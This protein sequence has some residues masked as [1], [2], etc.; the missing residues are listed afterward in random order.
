MDAHA[1]RTNDKRAQAVNLRASGA[2][3]I[4]DVR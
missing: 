2:K 1:G 3:P 4:S